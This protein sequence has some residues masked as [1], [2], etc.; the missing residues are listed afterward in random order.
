MEEGSDNYAIRVKHEHIS[1]AVAS[2][3]GPSG[4]KS[5][6]DWVKA[7]HSFLQIITGNGFYGLSKMGPE[8]AMPQIEGIITIAE[9]YEAIEAVLNDFERLFFQYVGHRKLW[10]AIAKDPIRY[11]KVGIAL[12][13]SSVYE[14]AFTHLVGSAAN[15]KIGQPYHDLPDV[16]QAAVERRSRELYHLRREVNEELLLITVTVESKESCAKS[17]IAS[18]NRSPVSWIVVNMFRDWIGEHLGH[19]RQES[20]DK[21]YPYELCKHEDN[22]YTVAGFYRTVAAGGDEYLRLDDINNDWNHNFFALEDGDEEVVK[23]A[24]V[25]LKQ[26]AQELVA[27]LIDS[28]LHLRAED[29][30]Q[31]DYLTCVKVQ[32]EDIPWST[33]EMDLDLD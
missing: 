10:E 21:P 13:I 33:E 11:I 24:L 8:A 32:P 19:L 17:Y 22:C 27:P 25:R 6:V 28:P 15:F 3:T 26:R 12:K 9:K 29:V 5:R 4:D 7:M 31:L 14:E 30:R 1:V 20:C 23:A 16:V 2:Q 18:Q